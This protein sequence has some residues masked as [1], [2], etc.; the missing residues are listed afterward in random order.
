MMTSRQ[1]CFIHGME[2]DAA[3]DIHQNVHEEWLLATRMN[4]TR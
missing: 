2:I 4:A 3:R 1:R